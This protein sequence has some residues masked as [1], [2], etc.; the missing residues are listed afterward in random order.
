MEYPPLIST[1]PCYPK[2]GPYS[3]SVTGSSACALA[4]GIAL[5]F[6][7]KDSDAKAA[8]LY[9]LHHAE[10]QNF[11]NFV[12]RS[13]GLEC[14]LDVTACAGTIDVHVSRVECDEQEFQMLGRQDAFGVQL[15]AH[16]HLLVLPNRFEE[17]KGI[18]FSI[19][20]PELLPLF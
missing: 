7:G 10:L 15:T 8:S 18:P 1:A 12:Y 11:H 2:R 17:K 9:P 5:Q 16:G 3:N 19:P 20:F 4:R 6:F 14:V 13:T